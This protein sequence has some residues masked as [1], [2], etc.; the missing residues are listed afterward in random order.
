VATEP[1][2]SDVVEDVEDAPS[3]YSTTTP[4]TAGGGSSITAPGAATGRR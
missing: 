3:N 2:A 1:T 4:G